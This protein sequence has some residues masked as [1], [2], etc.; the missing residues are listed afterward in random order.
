MVRPN[1]DEYFMFTAFNTSLRS[2]CMYI[3][4]GAVI[5]QDKRII[6]TGYNGAPPN[7]ENCLEKGC[8]KDRVGIKQE[9][10]GTGNCRGEHAER[11][12]ILQIARKDL[13][14]ATMYSVLFPCS[15]C[16][17]MIV[18]S[19]IRKVFYSNIYKEPDS[20]TQELFSEGGVALKELKL[21]VQDYYNKYMV[22][23][24]L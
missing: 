16:A 12:A 21:N 13:E 20:L 7:I 8:R 18:G 15:D 11:N 24:K 3:H 1:W 17:K 23:E 22:N 9:Q 2:S 19:G 5:V 6:A 10:K 14:G 4:T